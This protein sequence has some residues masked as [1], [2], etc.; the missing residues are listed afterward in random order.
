MSG[1][2][3]ETESFRAYVAII[4]VGDE[5]FQKRADRQKASV[6]SEPSSV[7]EER[8]PGTRRDESRRCEH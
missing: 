4:E 8:E 6:E 7:L 2:D 1:S 3:M 5:K